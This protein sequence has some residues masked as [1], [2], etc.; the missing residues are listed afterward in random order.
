MRV[1][2]IVLLVFVV[3]CS[4]TTKYPDYFT[5]VSGYMNSYVKTVLKDNSKLADSFFKKAEKQLLLA[6][7]NCNLAR[8]YIKRF[9]VEEEFNQNS[10]FYLEKAS[11]F[12]NLSDC[13]EEKKIIDGLLML[14]LDTEIVNKFYNYYFNYLKSGNENNL[15]TFLKKDEVP[16]YVKSK[17]FRMLAEDNFMKS[18]EKS[19][20]YINQA[21]QI[22]SFNSYSIYLLKDLN[23]MYKICEKKGEVCDNL[24]KRKTMLQEVIKK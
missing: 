20:Y 14:K 12:A 5:T 21:Y 13:D 3:S 22:D 7:D 2:F 16:D 18:L 17:V 19:E 24:E 15:L 6:D 10:L 1:I 11:V 23:I 4:K 9:F 8:I